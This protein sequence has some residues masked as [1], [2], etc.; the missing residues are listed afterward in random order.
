MAGDSTVFDNKEATRLGIK[1]KG[2][3]RAHE[4]AMIA[5]A[6]HTRRAE[7]YHLSD[8]RESEPDESMEGE[9]LFGDEAEGIKEVA[10]WQP[11]P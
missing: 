5:P 4:R 2:W 7:V 10:R 8:L 9:D 1:Q 11:T 6:I 3:E